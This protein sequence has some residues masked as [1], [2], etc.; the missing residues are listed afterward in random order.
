MSV[1]LNYNPANKRVRVVVT[2]DADPQVEKPDLEK[3]VITNH[4]LTQAASLCAKSAEAALS[5]ET[6]ADV[7]AEFDKRVAEVNAERAARKAA[8]LTGNL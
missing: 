8:K 6:D 2:F 4:L 5:C 7:D 3:N 1:D